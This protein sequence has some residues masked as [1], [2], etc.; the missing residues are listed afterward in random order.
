[1]SDEQETCRFPE[2]DNPAFDKGYCLEHAIQMEDW[3]YDTY[4]DNLHEP[5]EE[6]IVGGN[7]DELS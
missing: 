5:P 1:M 7:P 3:A 4:M 6:L 2:C